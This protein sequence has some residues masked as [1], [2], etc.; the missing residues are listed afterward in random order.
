MEDTLNSIK[1]LY[2]TLKK[3]SPDSQMVQDY[4]NHSKLS[5]DRWFALIPPSDVERVK[6]LFVNARTADNNRNCKLEKEVLESMPEE[7]RAIWLKR[8]EYIG[9]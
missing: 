8:I 3:D 6:Y 4:T 2:D 7:E 1:K 9:G 5:L